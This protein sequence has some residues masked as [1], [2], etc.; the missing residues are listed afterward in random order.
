MRVGISDRVI[1]AV[2]FEQNLNDEKMQIMQIVGDIPDRWSSKCKGSEAETSKDGNVSR[3][4]V[5]T[6]SG[7]SPNTLVKRLDFIPS[8]MRNCS[9]ILI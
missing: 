7:K 3:N 2:V 6:D 8:V 9:V 4:T 1:C 5:N